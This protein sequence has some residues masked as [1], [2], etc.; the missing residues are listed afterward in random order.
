[1]IRLIRLRRDLEPPKPTPT[2]AHWID[3]S[4]QTSDDRSFQTS[5]DRSVLTSIDRSV[6]T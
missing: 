5:D 4:F 6:P 1:L 3:R 2:T